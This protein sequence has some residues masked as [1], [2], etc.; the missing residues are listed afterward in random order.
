MCTNCA[1]ATQ[2]RAS[3]GGHYSNFEKLVS[4]TISADIKFKTSFH[5][6]T[7]LFKN[8]QSNYCTT[9]L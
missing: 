8:H 6:Q 7:K 3:T 4:A 9:N 1:S 5:S 2:G